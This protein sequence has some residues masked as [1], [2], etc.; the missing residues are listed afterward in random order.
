MVITIFLLSLYCFENIVS[1]IYRKPRKL[2]LTNNYIDALPQKVDKL[3]ALQY[4]TPL[5]AY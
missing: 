5:T 1:V 4:D 3:V 2:S